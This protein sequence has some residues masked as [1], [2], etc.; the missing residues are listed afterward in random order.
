MPFIDCKLNFKIT[1]EQ[2]D[3]IKTKLGKAIEMIPGKSESWLMIGFIDDYTLYFKGNDN[4]KTAFIDIKI[5][6]SASEDSYLKLTKEI[7]TIF[8]EV[9][10]IKSERVYITYSEINNWGWNGGNF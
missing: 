3:G 6:G 10:G 5:F 7:C 9:I 4:E 2:K 1:K 8:Y